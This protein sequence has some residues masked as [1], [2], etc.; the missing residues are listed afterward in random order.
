MIGSAFAYR[1]TA[2][3][4]RTEEMTKTRTTA[5]LLATGI[6]TVLV[7]TVVSFAFAAEGTIQANSALPIAAAASPWSLHSAAGSAHATVSPFVQSQ[8]KPVSPFPILLNRS[9]ERYVNAYLNQPA[10]LEAAFYRSRPFLPRMMRIMERHGVP[11]DF[12]YLAFAE[13]LFTR[14]GL[15]PWQF[16]KATARR[17]GLR[18]NRWVDERRDPILST[19]AAAE[20]LAELHDD[21]GKDWRVAVVGW[22][23][24]P[25]ALDRFWYLEGASNYRKFVDTLPVRTRLL[26]QRFMAVA[27]IADNAAAYG[28][29]VNYS[30]KTP[31]ATK[32][33][34]GGVSL[35]TIA[36]KYHTTVWKLR[37]LNPAILHDRL[38]PYARVYAVRLP[39]RGSQIAQR[40]AARG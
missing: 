2:K 32:G 18:I 4:T 23:L 36:R 5:A 26:L 22:N 37:R 39:L 6:L 14:H 15:G 19:K 1:V 24:G 33:F 16:D 7:F 31:Y 29:P 9:V 27:F 35:V 11:S 21:A 20:Y 38:P 13:S 40:T 30:G 17:F 25:G 12:V 3:G 8:P 34:R 28:I 10:T